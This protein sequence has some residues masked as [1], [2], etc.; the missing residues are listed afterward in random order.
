LNDFINRIDG[1]GAL[2]LEITFISWPTIFCN[3]S[4]SSA[5]GQKTGRQNRLFAPAESSVFF[6]FFR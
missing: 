5:L 6:I 4:T 1:R 2:Y 3:L